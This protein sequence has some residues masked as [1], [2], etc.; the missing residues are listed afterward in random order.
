VVPER[1][2]PW[3]GALSGLIICVLG[4]SLFL[5]RYVGSGQQ[6]H[7]HGHNHVP[8]HSSQH[9]GL[10]HDHHHYDH[11]HAYAHS[12]HTHPHHPVATV[13]PRDLLAL[14]V[15]GGIV[16]CPAALVVLL[17]A[18]SLGRIGFGLLLIVAFSMGLAAVLVLIGIL[19]V[20]ARRLMSHFHGD[21]R[22]LTRWLPLTSAAMIAVFG[23]VIAVQA[24]ASAGI[25]QISL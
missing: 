5:R 20:Y 6:S 12:S 24:L 8:G 15:T 25:L 19:M 4:L 7:H 22:L 21:G 14:G 11:H 23:V 3:L 13:T 9:H 10:H 2:Y 17:S 18:I 1:L 16:P